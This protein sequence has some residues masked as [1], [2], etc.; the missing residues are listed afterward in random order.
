[1]AI[2][3][4][5]S[6]ASSAGAY[7]LAVSPTAVGDVLVLWAWDY[8]SSYQ[9]SGV[10]GG[11]VS[12]WAKRIAYTPTGTAFEIWFG[13]ITATGSATITVTAGFRPQVM[14]PQ[15]FTAGFPGA[16]PADGNGA[17]GGSP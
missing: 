9:L 12:V 11:G 4:V 17:G 5:G 10:S 13:R 2:T 15:Q 14:G 1:M 3:A 6:L 7:T 16:W 8:N